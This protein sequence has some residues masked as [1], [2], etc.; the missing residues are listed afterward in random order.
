[1]LA[2]KLQKRQD[3]ELADTIVAPL[4]YAGRERR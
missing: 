2:S 4:A 1:M 3:A